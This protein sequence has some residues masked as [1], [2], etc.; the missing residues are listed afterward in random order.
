MHPALGHTAHRPFP[1]PGRG[2]VFKQRWMD[3]LFMH[4]PVPASALR[5]LVPAALEIDEFDGTSW[6]GVVPFHMEGIAPR[7]GFAVPWLSA[8]AELN[9]RLYVSYKGV[10]GVWFISLDAANPVAVWVARHV[11][12]LPYFNARMSVQAD[13][14]SIRYA[15]TRKT[16]KG[17]VSPAFAGRYKPTSGVYPSK[18]HSLDAFLTERYCLYTVAPLGATTD[19]PSSTGATPPTAPTPPTPPATGARPAGQSRGRLLRGHVHHAPWPLQRAEAEIDANTIATAQG[20]STTGPPI[21]HFSRR[22]DVALWWLE[23]LDVTCAVSMPQKKLKSTYESQGD[24]V[25]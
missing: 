12:H 4:W 14:D 6:V 25:W 8:F 18:P 21:L 20:I 11:F 2:W 10:A 15:S 22:I 16:A 24:K 13:A 5:A 3:L 23:K 19:R 17:T 1:L 9:L 7:G